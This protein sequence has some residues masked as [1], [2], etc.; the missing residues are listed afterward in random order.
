[1]SRKIA[2]TIELDA[3]GS[4]HLDVDGRGVSFDQSIIGLREDGKPA[5]RP[6]R[7]FSGDIPLALRWLVTGE[8]EDRP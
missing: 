8:P 3:D 6:T 5:K 2:A 1:V 4:I 7:Q